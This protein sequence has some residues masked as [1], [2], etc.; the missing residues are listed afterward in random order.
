MTRPSSQATMSRHPR[1]L[2]R[3]SSSVYRVRT[4]SLFSSKASSV[5]MSELG[6]TGSR[7]EFSNVTRHCLLHTLS[8]L[9]PNGIHAVLPA[10]G[11]HKVKSFCDDLAEFARRASLAGKKRGGGSEVAL[12]LPAPPLLTELEVHKFFE[13]AVS[14]LDFARQLEQRLVALLPVDFDPEVMHT[15]CWRYYGAEK[16]G[17]IAYPKWL[18]PTCTYRLWLI[19]NCV[20]GQSINLDLP[21]VTLN[22]VLRRMVELCGY[23]WNETYQFQVHKDASFPQCIEAITNYFDKLELETSLTCEV[24]ADMVD[25]VVHG[26]LRKSYLMKKG[27]KRKNWNKRWFILQRTILRYYKSREKL[28]QKVSYVCTLHEYCALTH[29]GHVLCTCR[30]PHWYVQDYLGL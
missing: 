2:A 21:A 8:E 16:K 29:A 26:V 27:H 15:I 6:G 10:S 18:S 3:L 11:S 1:F 30:R 5:A 23:T 7:F 12:S 13:G 19:F 25:E 4:V 22:E 9:A 14:V 20:L 28:E 17:E 24:I